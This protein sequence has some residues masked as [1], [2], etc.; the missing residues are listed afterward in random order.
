M[1]KSK[2][3]SCEDISTLSNNC[4]FNDTSC[5]LIGLFT[6]IVIIIVTSISVDISVDNEY[7]KIGINY[8]DTKNICIRCYED[9][10]KITNSSKSAN[11]MT[12]NQNDKQTS[13]ETGVI[14]KENE[15]CNNDQYQELANE[16]TNIIVVPTN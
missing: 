7:I 8:S 4:C 16:V 3:S 2:A 6:I 12:E 9:I 10:D 1:S 11:I 13:L 15:I 5:F 14:E